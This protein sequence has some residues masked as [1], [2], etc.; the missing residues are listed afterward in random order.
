[1]RASELLLCGGLQ[2]KPNP[3]SHPNVPQVH[4]KAPT[5]LTE[6]RIC[7]ADCDSLFS[8]CPHCVASKEQ[9]QMLAFMTLIRELPD[10]RNHRYKPR[11][12]I[13]SSFLEETTVNLLLL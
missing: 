6:T 11:V 3:E 5:E 8:F 13:F 10:V 2:H 12:D 9:T 1:M 4:S 7:P